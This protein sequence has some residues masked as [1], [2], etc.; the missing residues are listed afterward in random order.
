MS[1][2]HAPGIAARPRRC[3]RY[4]RNISRLGSPP[5][6]CL[7]DCQFESWL[8]NHS[9][10]CNI[11]CITLPSAS[12]TAWLVKFSEGMRL[13]KCFCLRFS[14]N[15]INAGI[16][17]SYAN[18]THLLHNVVDSR[19][20]FFKVGGQQ[21]V[22]RILGH[23]SWRKPQRLRDRSRATRDQSRGGPKRR[24]AGRECV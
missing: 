22:L 10:A 19:I 15:N 3:A 16:S 11:L 12:S 20:G 14:C 2:K 9:I 6:T 13:M 8:S 18:P 17:Y 1:S 5:S 23:P 4:R 24:H 21:L 7:S